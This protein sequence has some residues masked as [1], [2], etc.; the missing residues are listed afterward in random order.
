[1]TAGLLP[2]SDL[3]AETGC[4]AIVRRGAGVSGF[5]SAGT[6][7]AMGSMGVSGLSGFAMGMDSGTDSGISRKE[8]SESWAMGTAG[9][10]VSSVVNAGAGGEAG[11][12]VSITGAV[13][14]L[15][16][17]AG[18][19]TGSGRGLVRMLTSISWGAC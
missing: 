19:G 13:A 18:N 17:V 16:G 12:V 1:M 15:T 10:G 6:S 4:S 9:G 5:T 3:E 2:V 11:S 7:V 8:S 14:S